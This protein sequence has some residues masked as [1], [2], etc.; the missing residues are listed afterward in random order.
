VL[1]RPYHLKEETVFVSTPATTVLARLLPDTTLLRLEACHVDDAAAQITLL[2]RVTQA[3]APWPLCT[4]P[5]RR[6]HS[7]YARTLADLP[8][9]DYRMRLR[10]RVRKWLCQNSHCPRHI[11]TER[12]PTVAAP[13]AR[14]TL[15]LAQRLVALGLA[16]GGRA[17]VRLSQQ[18]D[19]AVSRTILLRGLRR[20]PAPSFPTPKVLGVD[21]F[22][23]RK[24]HTY[25]TILVDLE[26]RQPIALLPD[27][28]AAP[29]AQWLREHPGVEVIARDRAS[30]Y[31]EG[32]RQGAPAA[33]QVADRFHLLQNLA[34]ALT[35]VFTTHG[36]ALDAVNVTAHQQ[37]VPLPD[38]P[39]AVLVPPPPTPPA[40]EARAAQRAARRQARYDTVWAFHRQGWSTTAMAAQVGCSCRTIERYLQMPT[41]PVRQHRRHYGRSILNPYQASLLERWNAGCHTAIQ[42]F[43][44]IQARGYAGSYR[45]VTASVSRIRQAQGVPPRRQGRRQILPVVAEP[46]SQPLTPRR[47][48]WLVLRRAEQRTE[49]EAQQLTQLHAQ[50]AEVAE[51]IDL[52][53]DC[54]HLVRQRQPEHLDPWLERASTSALEAVRR[55]ANGLRDDYAAVKAGVTLPWSSGPVEGHI[56]R[57]KM[58]KRHMYGRARLDLLSRRFVLAPQ[59]EQ[60]PA[61]DQPV[62]AQAHQEAVAV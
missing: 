41:W 6:I 11:F 56:N 58:L 51:A 54:T 32:A 24:R 29:V 30:A 36:R 49:A 39:S 15:R 19:V 27:R 21:D 8:W 7:H 26:R 25:G 42:L 3:T 37:P 44:A 40:E 62:P 12:L 20:Q 9:A 18:W 1:Q 34:D 45:R 2:I 14:R 28:T 48:T 38:G 33:A 47:A 43:Q 31:A 60:T 61:P 52:A 50:S 57:L 53:Q 55:F 23:L 4:T 59:E 16:L 10:L 35:H 13:W 22:A 5:A 17:G 46:V